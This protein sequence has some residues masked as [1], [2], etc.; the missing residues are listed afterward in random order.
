MKSFFYFIILF[1]FLIADTEL[2]YSQKDSGFRVKFNGPNYPIESMILIQN[3]KKIKPKYDAQFEKI[4]KG[5]FTLKIESKFN[6]IIERQIDFS[7]FKKNVIILESPLKYDTVTKLELKD[8]IINLLNEGDTLVV[9]ISEWDHL[10]HDAFLITQIGNDFYALFDKTEGITKIKLSK[11]AINEFAKFEYKIKV[12]DKEDIKGG[13]DCFSIMLSFDFFV[14][15]KRYHYDSFSCQIYN[16]SEL[17]QK[18]KDRS[19]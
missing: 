18:F 13:E 10:S 6:H 7:S 12:N 11:K 15:N 1:V 17:E 3:K 14:K 19:L 5:I 9:I 4:P 16:F 2:S 8:P